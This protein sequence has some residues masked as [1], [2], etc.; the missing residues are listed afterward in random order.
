M[1]IL[2]HYSVVTEVAADHISSHTLPPCFL[3]QFSNKRRPLPHTP[4]SGRS[5]TG[6]RSFFS[7]GRE[8]DRDRGAG[9][10]RL[11]LLLLMVRLPHFPMLAAPHKKIEDGRIKVR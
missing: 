3:V 4:S 10:A 6:S 1:M 8:G 2:L 11:L 7:R 5:T 9:G